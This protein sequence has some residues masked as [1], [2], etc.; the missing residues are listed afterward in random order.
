MF[1]LTHLHPMIVHFPIALIIVGFAA[2]ITGLVLKKPFFNDAAMYLLFAGTLGA[3]AAYF[4]GDM[5]GDGISETGA[6]GS[7]IEIHEGSAVLTL[8]LLIVASAVRLTRLLY[9]RID[10]VGLQ[11][12]GLV[13][14]LVGVLSVARTGYYGGDLVYKHAAGVQLNLGFDFSQPTDSDNAMANPDGNNTDDEAEDDD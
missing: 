8:W 7:A 3:I 9:K 13:L 12:F 14:F 10:G 4:S 1:D 5:A 11:V 2:E 6:L